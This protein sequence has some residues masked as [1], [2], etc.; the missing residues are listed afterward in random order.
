MIKQN[1]SITNYRQ[2]FF[3]FLFYSIFV[4]E[5]YPKSSIVT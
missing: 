4:T 5:L 3:A 1:V 2:A